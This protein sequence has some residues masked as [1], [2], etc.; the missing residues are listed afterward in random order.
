MITRYLPVQLTEPER[1]SLAVEIANITAEI[2]E[3]EATLAAAKATIKRL[4]LT[5]ATKSK[6][7]KDG[8]EDREVE[9]S[10]VASG[11][12]VTVTRLDTGEVIDRRRATELERQLSLTE[13]V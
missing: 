1:S 9:C 10:E 3:A 11:I 7:R 13:T 12:Y 2:G 5:R 4:D 6:T 8:F